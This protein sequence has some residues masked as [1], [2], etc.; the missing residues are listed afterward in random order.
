MSE[1]MFMAAALNPPKTPFKINLTPVLPP[2]P[3]SSALTFKP[4][5][6]FPTLSAAAQPQQQEHAALLDTLRNSTRKNQVLQSI[7][8]TS[9]FN[10][11]S[12]TN[13]HHTVLALTSKTR[14][15][16]RDIYDSGEYL[17]LVTT[18]RHSAFDRILASIPFKGQVL[19]QTS[20]WWFERTQHITANAVVST[21][22]PNVTIAKKCSVFPVEFV[23]E[24]F[25]NWYFGL[26]NDGIRMRLALDLIL[27]PHNL[28]LRN[29]IESAT[30]NY[31]KYKQDES[32]KN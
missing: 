31:N 32:N 14:G 20:L 21:P 29:V 24:Y 16:V 2:P 8:T 10:C 13:L 30:R 22:D 15:K 23:G 19:N 4:N 5:N 1:S 12:E 11:L 28:M 27:R 17:V 7:R 6:N 25:V 18:D 3:T 26:V 9:P